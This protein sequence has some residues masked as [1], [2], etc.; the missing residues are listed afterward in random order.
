MTAGYLQGS[1]FKAVPLWL[2][3]GLLRTSIVLN[4]RNQPVHLK[5]HQLHPLHQPVLAHQILC[6][7]CSTA[8]TCYLIFCYYKL[9]YKTKTYICEKVNFKHASYFYLFTVSLQSAIPFYLLTVTTKDVFLI[10]AMFPTQ[11]LNALVCRLTLLRVLRLES[12][13]IGGTIPHFVVNC[14]S[15]LF[16]CLR[17]S[18]IQGSKYTF[19]SL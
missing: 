8:G 12:A 4:A 11:Q 9:K 1:W 10:A 16:I 3:I 17:Y 2:I 13:F 5:I 19:L 6:V 7:I 18:I 14:L 15:L